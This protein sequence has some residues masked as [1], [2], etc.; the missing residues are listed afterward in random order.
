MRRR[1]KRE[2][3]DQRLGEIGG[4]LKATWEVLGEVLRG[5]RGKGKGAAC[6]YFE[7]GGVA[8]TDGARIA[9]G[10]CDFYCQVGPKLAAR[11][12]KE[13]DGAFLE[14]MGQRVEESLVWSPTTPAEVEELCRALQPGKGVGWDGVSPRVVIWLFC[15]SIVIL[16]M[17]QI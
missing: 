10:F 1:L 12:G 7:A 4:D 3:F 11:V 8:V 13:R 6:R 17:H 5:K 9:R 14:Y 2:Y 16:S 15:K